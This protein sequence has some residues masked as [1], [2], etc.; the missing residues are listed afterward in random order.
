MAIKS[1]SILCNDQADILEGCPKITND[2]PENTYNL[3]TTKLLALQK[4]RS[5]LDRPNPAAHVVTSS[6]VT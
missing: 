5:F 3:S 2:Y 4:D 6:I 1:K